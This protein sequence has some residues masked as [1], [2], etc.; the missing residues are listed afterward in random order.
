MQK[1]TSLG[2]KTGEFGG[3]KGEKGFGRVGE[4]REKVA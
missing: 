3:K 4:G 1:R 2:Q